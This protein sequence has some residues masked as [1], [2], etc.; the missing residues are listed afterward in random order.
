MFEALCWIH[1]LFTVEILHK[2]SPRLR[3]ATLNTNSKMSH[4]F[5]CGQLWLKHVSQVADSFLLPHLFFTIQTSKASILC[6]FNLRL[7]KNSSWISYTVWNL[8][9]GSRL[10]GITRGCVVKTKYF[11][12]CQ[13]LCG[14]LPSMSVKNIW[15]P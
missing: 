7:A 14:Y 15:I 2:N 4:D 8:T 11:Q 12:F 5:V 1:V 3:W 13:N 10:F 6:T 9:G